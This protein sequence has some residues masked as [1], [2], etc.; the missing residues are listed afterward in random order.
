MHELSTGNSINLP[1][2]Q[3]Q[4]LNIKSRIHLTMPGTIIATIFCI[5]VIVACCAS[6]DGSSD[7]ASPKQSAPTRRNTY[8]SHSYSECPSCGAPYYNGYC[9][10]CGYPD[11][12]QGW[13]GEEYN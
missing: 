7:K 8:H 6:V 9:D 12:N 2:Q 10:E 13:L 4:F 3:K 5:I 11:V 1:I